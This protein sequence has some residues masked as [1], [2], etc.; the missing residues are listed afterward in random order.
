MKFKQNIYDKMKKQQQK[1]FQPYG[2]ALRSI[3]ELYE[4]WTIEVCSLFQKMQCYA[5]C[6]VVKLINKKKHYKTLYNKYNNTSEKQ[7]GCTPYAMAN[8]MMATYTTC[9]NG[10]LM[11]LCNKCHSNQKKPWNATYV[12]YQAPS[13]MATLLST[14][15]IHV[16]L[17]YFLN[18]TLQMQLQN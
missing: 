14:H 11:Y 18:I 7:M 12:V 17:L 9:N 8:V 10:K 4:K 2:Q 13:Y 1:K 6:E 16:Q 5:I 15:P 3:Y